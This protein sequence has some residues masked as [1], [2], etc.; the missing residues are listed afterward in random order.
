MHPRLAIRPQLPQLPHLARLPS[1]S[2]PSLPPPQIDSPSYYNPVEAS[3][4]VEV[5]ER[6]LSSNDIDIGTGEI[7]VIAAFRSQVG[8]PTS[9]P[10]PLLLLTAHQHH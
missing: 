3:A 10:L 4:V 7:G 9:Q 2:S 5:V 6:M 8:T 1:L